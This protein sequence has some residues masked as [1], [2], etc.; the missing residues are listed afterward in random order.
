MASLGWLAP[1]P[2]GVP[3]HFAAVVFGSVAFVRLLW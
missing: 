3:Y 1:E 2:L